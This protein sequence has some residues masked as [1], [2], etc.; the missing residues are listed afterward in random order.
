MNFLDLTR[1]STAGGA[2][3]VPTELVA[4]SGKHLLGEGVILARTEAGIERCGKNVARNGFFDCRHDGPAAFAGIL[5]CA[6]KPREIRIFSKRHCG[7]VEQPG[8]NDAAATPQLSDIG[9]IE[10][11]AMIRSD[12]L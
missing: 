1:R 11:V 12:F 7:E 9:Q 3:D 4:H 8:S 6:S 5:N 2:L 10:C